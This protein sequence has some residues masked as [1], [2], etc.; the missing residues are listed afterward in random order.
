M[1]RTSVDTPV[2]LKFRFRLLPTTEEASVGRRDSGSCDDKSLQLGSESWDLGHLAA[3]ER[4]GSHL[5]LLLQPPDTPPLAVTISISGLDPSRLKHHL[6]VHRT[7]LRA[8]RAPLHLDTVQNKVPA[9][10]IVCPACD[11]TVDLTSFPPTPQMFCPYCETLSTIQSSLSPPPNEPDFRLCEICGMFS[12]PQPFT[13]FYFYYLIFHSGFHA[14]RS[15]RCRGCM[16][17]A[18]WKMLA[19]NLLFVVGVFPALV[20]LTR[21]Y[22]KNP[23]KGAYSGL[24]P[25]NQW[26]RRGRLREAIEGYR[27]ILQHVHCAAGIYYNLGMT[28][29]RGNDLPHAASVLEL[30]LEDCANYTPAY[31]LLEKCYQQSGQ[32]AELEALQLRWQPSPSVVPVSQLGP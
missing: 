21:A 7:R 5:L 11:V 18:A 8:A 1:K 25:A 13:S 28:L 3:V 30:A 22:R 23:D 12:R 27:K 26:A 32:F 29:Y 15:T 4:D 10:Q 16:R 6:D 19:G 24:E 14:R 31:Q 20:Q 9:R 2:P 17:S